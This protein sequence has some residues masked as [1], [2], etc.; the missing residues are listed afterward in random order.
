MYYTVNK[1]RYFFTK[2]YIM[3]KHYFSI[4]ILFGLGLSLFAQSSSNEPVR[5]GFVVGIGIGGSY[6][7]PKYKYGEIS[8]SLDND[9]AIISNVKIGFAPSDQL[10]I[11]WSSNINWHELEKQNGNEATFIFSQAGLGVSFF[12]RPEPVTPYVSVGFGYSS[13]GAPFE[14]DVD[15]FYGLGF[16][17]GGGH[18]F[19]K[20]F[21]VQAD[22]IWGN[23]G[24]DEVN[25]RLKRNTLGVALSINYLFY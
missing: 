20:H 12:L 7:V 8:R 21:A 6:L 19:A 11:Y 10:M 1:L 18:E 22:L 16:C 17:I 13:F 24:M 23:P 25:D 15:P 9:F 14:N 4:I 2:D 3:H 5:K